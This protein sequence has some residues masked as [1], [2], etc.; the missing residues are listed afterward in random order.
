M[1][2]RLVIVH[3][4]GVAPPGEG[5]LGSFDLPIDRDAPVRGAIASALL[6]EYSAELPDELIREDGS[7]QGVLQLAPMGFSPKSASDAKRLEFVGPLVGADSPLIRFDFHREYFTLRDVE[8]TASLGF[9]NNDGAEW[10]VTIDAG[11]GG[12]ETWFDIVAFLL[13][14]GVD[15][16]IG[17]TLE[18]A[19]LRGWR[20]IRN[21]AR[22]RRAR[23]V[24]QGWAAEQGI[25]NP[26]T[27]RWFL[28][29]KS[30]WT[31]EEV[32]KRLGISN[33]ASTQLL[34]ALGHARD[35]GGGWQLGTR[36]RHLKRRARW[37][38]DEGAQ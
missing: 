2:T 19:W 30:R 8:R 27:L 15:I 32:A 21:G 37:I 13:D 7:L 4:L 9:L 18:W 28:D 5:H 6:K 33:D 24:A 34:L 26:G 31:E 36:K 20:F 35:A 22:D 17:A 14:H 3:V 10:A 11:Y 23:R 25:T 38:R 16:G 29:L 1:S 12:D